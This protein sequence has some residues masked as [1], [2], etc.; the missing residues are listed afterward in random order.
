[1]AVSQY[2]VVVPEHYDLATDTYLF[3]GDVVTD[4][5]LASNYVEPD[6]IAELLYKGVL[7][8]VEKEK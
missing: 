3:D 1:M 4:D 8:P 5:H 2:T 6:R 7:E